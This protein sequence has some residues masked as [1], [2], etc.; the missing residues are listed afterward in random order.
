MNEYP[1]EKIVEGLSKEETDAAV[2]V[3]RLINYRSAYGHNPKYCEASNILLCLL[4]PSVEETFDYDSE[5]AKEALLE[6]CRNSRKQLEEVLRF[7]QK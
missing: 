1:D 3:L 6:H 5:A 7:N 4:D 2:K